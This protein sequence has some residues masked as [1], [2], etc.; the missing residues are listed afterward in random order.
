MNLKV[1]MR[2]EGVAGS[3]ITPMLSPFSTVCPLFT[4]ILLKLP[5]GGF[6]SI[7]MVDNDTVPQ[8][9]L[10]ACKGNNSIVC[11]Q[12]RMVSDKICTPLCTPAPTRAESARYPS[13]GYRPACTFAKNN[14]RPFHDDRRDGILKHLLIDQLFA[15]QITILLHKFVHH[16]LLAALCE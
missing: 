7:F 12:N 10:R 11:S 8:T 14:L 13:A 3:P 9:V 4:E 16:L 2:P 15:H 6:I 1:Q 5:V